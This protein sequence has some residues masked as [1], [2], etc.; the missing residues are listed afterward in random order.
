MPVA[1]STDEND[2][3]EKNSSQPQQ[4]KANSDE[5]NS[6]EDNEYYQRMQRAKKLARSEITVHQWDRYRFCDLDL[7]A[8]LGP[9]L[10]NCERIDCKDVTA[11][12]FRERFELPCKPC[13]ISGL[14]ERWPA[15]HK[16]TYQSLKD[17]FA[18]SR[19]KCGEDDDGYKVPHRP[20][21]A[22]PNAQPNP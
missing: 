13:V 14:L 20:S 7:D 22:Q 4:Q 15:Y 16:W 2:A 11:E 18:S 10:D 19:L 1:D 6:E 12:E 5:A 8:V 17:R 9:V 21:N 3:S